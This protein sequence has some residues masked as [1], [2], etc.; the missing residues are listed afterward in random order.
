VIA[1]N[2]PTVRA[3]IIEPATKHPPAGRS[4]S[5]ARAAAAIEVVGVRARP[6]MQNDRHA[7]GLR[8]PCL[9]RHGAAGHP[10]AVT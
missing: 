10:G 4:G 6:G 7:G 3:A 2:G 8:S 1:V 9:A 5:P